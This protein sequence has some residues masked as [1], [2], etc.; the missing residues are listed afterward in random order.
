MDSARHDRINCCA[1]LLIPFSEPGYPQKSLLAYTRHPAESAEGTAGFG[2]GKGVAV[3][4]I[5]KERWIIPLFVLVVVGCGTPETRFLTF[6][7][8]PAAADIASFKYHD[9]FPDEEAGPKT[10]N[11]PRV[12]IQPRSETQKSFDKR[13]INAAYGFPQQRYAW[14]SPVTANVSQYPVTPLWRGQSGD[15]PI[16][17]APPG[18]DLPR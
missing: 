5:A 18:L 9:P 7:P 3:M 13:Y 11:R 10:F 16:S 14:D 4:N 12:F 15:Q 6:A 1:W 17:L 2:L 8:R